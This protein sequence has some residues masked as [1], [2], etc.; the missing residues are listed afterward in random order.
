MHITFSAVIAA[1]IFL[2]FVVHEYAPPDVALIWALSVIVAYLPRL[3]LTIIF[4]KRLRSHRINP[5]NIR[6]WEY[7]FF[8]NSILPFLCFTAV[9]YLPYREG[10]DIS[11]LFGSYIIMCI[12]AGSILTYSTSRITTILFLNISAFSII[13]RSFLVQEFL[14]TMLG[15]VVCIGYILLM[16]LM[17]RLNKVL[18][19]NISLKIENKNY[20]L[21]DPLT[22]LWNR[23]HLYLYIEQLMPISRRSGDPFSIIILDIDRFKKYNDTHGHL[24]GDELLIK[25][26]KQLVN[27]SRQQDLIVRYGGEEFLLVLPSTNIDQA[28]VIAE[29][30]LG[31]VRKNTNVT[32]SAGLSVYSGQSDFNQLIEQADKALYTA[33]STGRDRF[34]VAEMA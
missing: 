30:I 34:V 27:C 13:I 31:A 26:A 21:K 33:K 22:K 16:I 32:I 9:I 28:R 11:I 2:Y 25:V 20:S 29:R 3:V 19:E 10:T 6:P 4:N 7:Y 15:L 18:I 14:F 24:E 23:R 8:L 1:V 17:L 12:T 5:N